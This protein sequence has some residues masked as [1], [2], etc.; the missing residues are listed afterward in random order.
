MSL[1]KIF[2]FWP[3]HAQT[4]SIW[5]TIELV[6]LTKFHEKCSK[7]VDF[8][9]ITH[10]LK[11]SLY[12]PSLLINFP[13]SG[14]NIKSPLFLKMLK[15]DIKIQKI[16]KNSINWSEYIWKIVWTKILDFWLKWLPSFYF[17]NQNF[18]SVHQKSNRCPS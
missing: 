2:Q 7:I 11:G 16:V 5:P 4:L 3:N 9:L 18:L 6:I 13:S 12:R 10:F 8:L 15:S 1:M 14:C 17:W